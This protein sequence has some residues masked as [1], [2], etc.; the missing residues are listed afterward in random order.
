MRLLDTF[1]NASIRLKL[2][3]TFVLTSAL[4]FIVNLYVYSNLNTMINKVDEIYASNIALTEMEETLEGL[5]NS[6]TEYLRTKSSD[7]LELYY[8]NE[9]D[10]SNQV[11]ALYDGKTNDEEKMMEKTIWNL[12]ES[13][14]TITEETVQA[15]R[16]RNIER[17]VSGYENASRLFAYINTYISS[18]NNEQFKD[19]SMNYNTLLASLK[20]SEYFCL[21]IL[22]LIAL[23]NTFIVLLV[24]RSIT[25]PLM[26]LSKRADHVAQGELDVELLVIKSRDE[27]GILT[28]AFNKMVISL[29]EYIDQLRVRMELENAMKERELMMA[30]HLKD[31]QL[32]YL[33]AQIHPH[34]LF[35]TLNAGA[36]LAML[37]G[38]DR[39]N[40][41]IQNMADFFRYN[42]KKNNEKVTIAE[43]IELVDSYIYILN[44][45][46]A[47]DIHFEK[48]L[49]EA[50][51]TL[52]VPSMII[53]PV[54]ENS[55]HYGIRNIDREGQ[56]KLSL[57]REGEY[58]CISV[59][60]NGIGVSQEMIEKIMHREV[61]ASDV[62]SDSNGVGLSNVITRL[63]LFFGRDDIFTIQSEG[64]NRGTQTVIR[65]PCESRREEKN[66]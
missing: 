20:L 49:D 36:Q 16:G 47:G 14:L 25:N 52:N 6:M 12:S 2:V 26:E 34:F 33:Q 1:R 30:A 43:E 13:Y 38:A 37:E 23:F 19:N 39:T 24:T 17:Y 41:Y 55:V 50:L 66:P 7:A 58:A 65:I 10:F 51:L 22:V 3:I 63:K 48:E 45:R 29:R 5:Q 53:Q 15:K 61:T 11:N 40:R 57:Y 56:I 32:K 28:N 8:K 27:V 54:V 60:D 35:N 18:L 62:S 42:V 46:F 21:S 9:Q 4:I 64:E 59:A 31:A 44:V